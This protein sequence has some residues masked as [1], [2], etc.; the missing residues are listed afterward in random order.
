MKVELLKDC[1]VL[2]NAGAVVEVSPATANF[3]T[4]VGLAKEA[5]EPEKKAA[6]RVKK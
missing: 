2:L 4:S 6:K 5:N 1:R 3:L